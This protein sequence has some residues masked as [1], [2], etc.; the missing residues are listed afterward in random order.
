MLSR[1]RLNETTPP[2]VDSASV[3]SSKNPYTPPLS[4]VQKVIEG[5]KDLIELSVSFHYPRSF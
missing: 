3:G 5:N 4:V 2:P 1:E